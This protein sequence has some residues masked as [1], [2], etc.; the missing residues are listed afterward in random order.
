MAS[1]KVAFDKK[2]SGDKMQVKL[3]VDFSFT[4]KELE[5]FNAMLED[6]PDLSQD[7][8]INSDATKTSA[9][10]IEY[11]IFADYLK[12]GYNIINKEIFEKKVEDL[13]QAFLRYE[14]YMNP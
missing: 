13:F 10:E 2:R 7:L 14:E 3:S 11:I 5:D 12:S 9:E 6:Y 4:K 1:Y 8:K